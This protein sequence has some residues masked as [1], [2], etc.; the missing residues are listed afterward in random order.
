MIHDTNSICPEHTLESVLVFGL[1]S[2]SYER[3]R[4]ETRT[5]CHHFSARAF[6]VKIPK[7]QDSMI[8]TIF[9]FFRIHIPKMDSFANVSVT[10]PGR[11]SARP[12]ARPPGH[13]KYKFRHPKYSGTSSDTQSMSSDTQSK[14]TYVLF[15]GNVWS[16]RSVYGLSA[17]N[18]W[19]VQSIYEPFPK[20]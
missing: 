15:A 6:F 2:V 10:R 14:T 13:P 20:S 7:S 4:R 19:S 3:S 16:L 12:P 9:N 5:E 8:Y 1:E 17:R 11:P 18:T